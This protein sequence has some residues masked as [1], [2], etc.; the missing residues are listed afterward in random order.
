MKHLR[1][2]R[3]TNNVVDNSQDMKHFHTFQRFI[4][5]VSPCSIQ[6]KEQEKTLKQK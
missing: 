5:V 6:S 4:N 2:L 3:E 1:I